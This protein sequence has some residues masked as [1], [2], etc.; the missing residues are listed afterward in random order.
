ME[1]RKKTHE[2]PKPKA[3]AKDVL[4]ASQRE[5]AIPVKWRKHYHRLVE[6]RDH[7][8]RQRFE[9]T[10]DALEEKPSFSTH[11][12]DAGTDSYDRDF[13][14]GLLSSDQDAVYE[15]EEALQRIRSGN[16]GV[17]ELTG[18][19]IEPARLEVIPWTRF[20]TEA[21]KQLEREGARKSP[22]LG[23]R[24]TVPR[25]QAPQNESDSP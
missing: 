3:S 24:E 23:D 25:V 9:L 1:R 22:R 4:G 13:A 21:E 11:M 19:R 5:P 2:R 8:L 6:L 18:Q 20:S 17:C 14:L 7:L 15:V 12:A 16:F 10:Q